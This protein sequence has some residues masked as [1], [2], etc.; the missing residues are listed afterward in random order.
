ML[1]SLLFASLFLIP[2]LS[3]AAEPATKPRASGFDPPALLVAKSG[4]AIYVPPDD[5]QEAEYI[6][7]DGEEA[8]PV[9]LIG[10]RKTAFVFLTRGLPAKN[11]RF[12]GVASDSTGKL[13]RKEFAVP[14]GNPPKD[15]PGTTP[16]DPPAVPTGTYYFLIVRSDGPASPAFTKLMGLPE[17][18]LLRSAGHLVKDMPL[19]EATALLSEAPHALPPGTTLPVVITIQESADSSSIAR[20]AIPL[21]TTPTGI[22]DL[23]KGV[24]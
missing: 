21:P 3:S 2:S 5:V 17:W 1:R 4:V 19:K 16:K 11:Y 13:T 6:A 14:V 12:V 22:L 15:P 8:F 10:G 9:S 23:P 7:L 18:G 20:N 24:K